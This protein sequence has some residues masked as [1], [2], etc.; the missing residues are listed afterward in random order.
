MIFTVPIAFISIL[1]G[2]A[3]PNVPFV[4]LKSLRISISLEMCSLVPESM[5]YI[6]ILSERFSSVFVDIDH[7]SSYRRLMRSSTRAVTSFFS[8]LVALSV[9]SALVPSFD[10][11][12]EDQLSFFDDLKIWQ[13]I[14][15]GCSYRIS[16]ALMAC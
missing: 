11:L 10:W 3:V 13:Y 12:A 9:F 8:I 2:P 5:T 1:A 14:S 7:P 4:D 6:N 15:Y 16:P